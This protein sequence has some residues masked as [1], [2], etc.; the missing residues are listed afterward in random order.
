MIYILC[1]TIL[2]CGDG[3]YGDGCLKTCR[4]E[5]GSDRCD[6]VSGCV[7]KAGWKGEYC[8]EDIDECD[9]SSSPCMGDKESCI[10][11]VGSYKCE[12]REGFH[13]SSG[14]CEGEGIFLLFHSF[15]PRLFPPQ[16]PTT[17]LE[18]ILL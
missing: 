13:N 8:S 17:T 6:P 11:T 16:S 5:K 1:H 3:F 2:A 14:E 10:N 7:C 12:C 15:I 9:N 4:C 18:P